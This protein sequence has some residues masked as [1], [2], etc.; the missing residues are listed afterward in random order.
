MQRYADNRSYFNPIKAMYWSLRG[1]SR[2]YEAKQLLLQ[3]MER[4]RREEG[5]EFVSLNSSEGQA[6]M[7]N[8][9]HERLH[10]EAPSN[11]LHGAE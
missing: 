1:R 7:N 4:W 6:M 3:K 10:K 5:L 2:G 11:P 9:I 8:R